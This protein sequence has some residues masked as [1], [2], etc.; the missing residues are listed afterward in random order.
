MVLYEQNYPSSG[1][2]RVASSPISRRIHWFLILLLALVLFCVGIFTHNVSTSLTDNDKKYAKQFLAQAGYP[3]AL[4]AFGDLN[5]FDNQV[6]AIIAVQDAVFSVAP[7]RTAIPLGVTREPK[8]VFQRKS[9][10]CYDLSRTIEKLLTALGLENRHIALYS[11]KITK[12]GLL[13]LVT[14]RVSSHALTEVKTSKGWILIDS[15]ERWIGLTQDG[16]P[17]ALQRQSWHQ[18]A[19]TK[20]SHLNKSKISG[21]LVE[22]HV[23]VIGLY[24][25]HGQFY[26]P[27]NAIPDINVRQ[28]FYN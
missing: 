16:N 26:P 19:S 17:V 15:L 5:Q 10:I 14:P 20:W 27:F 1:Y 18:L 24:S 7:I 6:R 25:R 11:T 21:L 13:S 22:P 23:Y 2:S 3:D 9:G 8:D 28:L 4:S 12:S